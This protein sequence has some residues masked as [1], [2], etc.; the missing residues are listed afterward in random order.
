MDKREFREFD[1]EEKELDESDD[2][3][4]KFDKSNEISDMVLGDEEPEDNQVNSKEIEK[5][6]DRQ[7]LWIIGL[8][9][10]VILI[11]LVVP[12]TTNY[13]VKEYVN[14]FE[15]MRLEFEKTALGD[16]IIY[17][18]Y[19]PV[20]NQ[21]GEITSN[22]RV[23]FRNDPRELSQI[24]ID[25]KMKDSIKF[26]QQKPVYIS[27][28]PNMDTC[29][30]NSVAMIIL[31]SFL[32]DSGLEIKSAMSDEEYANLTGNEYKTCK[33]SSKNTVIIVDS[34]NEL[35]I[36]QERTNCYKIVYSD[37]EIIKS[38]ER[39]NLA[40]LE[41]YMNHFRTKEEIEAENTAKEI[42]TKESSEDIVEENNTN[43]EIIADSEK[44]AE[45]GEEIIS[46]SNYSNE[47]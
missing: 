17:S 22:Y 11:V 18:A 44:E 19:V 30:D 41:N 15:F 31:S 7:F 34:G 2:A 37:C 26:I 5:K 23:T 46:G 25:E 14:K 10:A 40:I 20:V 33:D 47:G 3:L 42:A 8:M 9:V 24:E 16:I 27:I 4:E 36:A 6:Q 43:P 39:F 13:V 21:K 32:R 35:K 45:S 38:V 1:E 28:N 29:E 12:Y